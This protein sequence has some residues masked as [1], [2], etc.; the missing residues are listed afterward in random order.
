MSESDREFGTTGPVDRDDDDKKLES[1][2]YVPS[3]KRE[4]SNLATVRDRHLIFPSF[5]LLSFCNASCYYTDQLCVQYHGVSFLNLYAMNLTLSTDRAFAH[6]SQLHSIPRCSW[7]ALRQYVNNRMHMVF[8]DSIRVIPFRRRGAG[9]LEPSC[10]LLSVG[11]PLSPSALSTDHFTGTSI[12]E[13]VSAF[14]TCGGLCVSLTTA[15]NLTFTHQVSCQIH[16]IFAAR[17]QEAPT[18]REC[19]F[20]AGP[21]VELN[22]S[23][24]GWVVGWLNILGQ[25]AG[26][27]STE[28]GLSS[29]I[30]AAVVVAKDG[31]YVVTSG[32]V[33]GLF[34]ALL[35]LHGILVRFSPCP[36][37]GCESPYD[38]GVKTPFL[39]LRRIVLRRVI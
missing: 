9:F 16:C 6:L 4:F 35:I 33:V 28:F 5:S 14:P 23:K 17:A 19:F 29:M 20:P 13:I 21:P 37:G 10:V 15:P 22:N 30:W 31:N 7:E 3:F 39:G 26:I 38:M 25:V 27:S 36:L 2:G 8:Y 18:N 24:V 12:A 34:A 32:K 1:L 11:H